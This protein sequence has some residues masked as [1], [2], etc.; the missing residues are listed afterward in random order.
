MLLHIKSLASSLPGWCKVKNWNALKWCPHQILESSSGKKT[1]WSSQLFWVSSRY[2]DML[3]SFLISLSANSSSG[4][5][6]SEFLLAIFPGQ[7]LECCLHLQAAHIWFCS[8]LHFVLVSGF[9]TVVFL[10][11]FS[12]QLLFKIF[13]L[14]SQS[15]LLSCCLMGVYFFPERIFCPFVVNRIKFR[16]GTLCSCCWHAPALYRATWRQEPRHL[17]RGRLLDVHRCPERSR[18]VIT[19]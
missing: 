13:F 18:A 4:K 14:P 11:E 1:S 16:S 7:N 12:I 3:L 10:M 9:Y 6:A 17:N 15:E 8:C 19:G 5:W 2:T